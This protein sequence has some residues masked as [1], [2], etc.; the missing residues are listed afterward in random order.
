MFSSS[1]T[2]LESTISCGLLLPRPG[3]CELWQCAPA[4]RR[5]TII[6]PETFGVSLLPCR[7]RLSDPLVVLPEWRSLHVAP[8]VTD[9]FDHPKGVVVNG[10]GV[11]TLKIRDKVNRLRPINAV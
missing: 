3:A 11:D 1:R 4:S 5:E 7:D 8:L 2:L 9:V 10:Q 6:V